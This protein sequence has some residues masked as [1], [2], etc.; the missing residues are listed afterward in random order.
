MH[1]YLIRHGQSYVNLKDWEDGNLDEGLTELGQQQAAAL[2]TWMPVAVP[3]IDTLY[4]STMRRARETAQYL[5]DAYQCGIEF[6][7]RLREIGNN[8]YDHTPWPSDDLPKE[9]SDYWSSERPFATSTPIVE[10]GETFMHFRTRVGLFIEELV[11]CCRGKRVLA[12]CHGGVVEAAFD[13]IFNI[14]PWRRCE[15]W[16]HNTGVTYFEYVEIP[17]RETWRL[18]FHNRIDHLVQ[19]ITAE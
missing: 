3:E 14:G 7:D 2:G 6:D 18:H 10:G 16:D 17:R 1:L 4:A 11:T 13:H 9:Y 8:R 5:A 12:V 15:I 19:E